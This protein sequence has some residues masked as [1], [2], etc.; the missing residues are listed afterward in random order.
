MTVRQQ[1]ASRVAAIRSG[2]VPI[3]GE[4]LWLNAVLPALPTEAMRQARRIVNASG[5]CG[6]PAGHLRVAGFRAYHLAPILVPDA[7]LE[8]GDGTGGFLV[9]TRLLYKDQPWN[10]SAFP[11]FPEGDF[12]ALLDALEFEPGRAETWHDRPGML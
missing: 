5:T 2:T 3:D 6:A 4:S 1:L 12:D 8:A 10:R 7:V 11:P 9:C